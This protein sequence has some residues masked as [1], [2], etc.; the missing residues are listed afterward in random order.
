LI[1]RDQ[2]PAKANKSYVEG[3]GVGREMDEFDTIDE[4]EEL[5]ELDELN[6]IDE[7]DEM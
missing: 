1:R 5:E 4:I 6:E 7:I 2:L 3:E